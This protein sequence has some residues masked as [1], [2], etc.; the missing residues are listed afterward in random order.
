LQWG[1]FVLVADLILHTT[2]ALYVNEWE[3]WSAVVP[4]VVFI[5][6]TGLVVVGVSFGVLAR[7]GLRPTPVGRNRAATA[8]LIAGIASVISYAAIAIWAPMLIAPAALLLALAALRQP[9]DDGGRVRAMAGGALG[10][11]SLAAW[12]WFVGQV[13]ITGEFPFSF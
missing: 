13:L 1:I 4:L 7:W 10:A 5:L 3:G 6:I 9:R 12:V 2:A 11:L 8:A